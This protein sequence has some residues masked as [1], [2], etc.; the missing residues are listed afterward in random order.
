MANLREKVIC[1][2]LFS[3]EVGLRNS[4]SAVRRTG[5]VLL[6]SKA[7]RATPP[8]LA[9]PGVQ[10]NACL[11]HLKMLLQHVHGWGVE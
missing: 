8:S 2:I 6:S 5:F 9:T 4:C 1:Y 7:E 11:L 3:S 10:C